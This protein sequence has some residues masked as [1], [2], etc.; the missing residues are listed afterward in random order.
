MDS[1]NRQTAPSPE[2]LWLLEN[3]RPTLDA[4]NQMITIV[5]AAGHFVY[6]N[7][8]AARLDGTDP[9]QVIGCHILDVSPWLNDSD[10]T[11]LR[12]LHEQISFT[13]S[14]QAYQG[15][16]GQH[17]HYVHSATPL[18]GQDGTLI[19]AM[20]VGRTVREMPSKLG[21]QTPPPDILTADAALRSQVNHIDIFGATDLPILIYGESGTGKELFARRAHAQSPRASRPMLSL[22]CAAIPDTLLESTLFG[23]TKGAFTGAENRKGLFTL[24]DGA[25]LFL[26]EINS[27]PISLQGKL[28]RVLQDGSFLPLG[29]SQPQTVDVRLIA[30]INQHP[31]TAIADGR[32]RNDLYY[33]LSVGEIGTIP[34]RDR[35]DDILL[36]SQ[37]FIS[38]FAPT[39]RPEVVELGEQ[40]KKTLTSY[41][42][43]GNVRELE[44]LIRR[45]LLL[46]K[47]GS[48]LEHIAFSG[49]P[50]ASMPEHFCSTGNLNNHLQQT[51]ADSIL[52][53]LAACHS[54]VSKTAKQLGI[55]R[56]TLVSKMKRLGMKNKT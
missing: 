21:E 9:E 44:N 42:W 20:E 2:L 40:A 41:H 15:F 7:Q 47:N 19:G 33:R 14:Y 56:T 49:A 46:H 6:Y 43:P 4:L 13:D 25:T 36:L 32:L 50:S 8:S 5:D 27:M 10:S 22:N 16:G 3:I 34:L 35:P 17:L 26:D 31:Q 48:S 52:Q 37:V 39:L 12:C 23:T 38:Q 29:G 1:G 51:E 54:N 24:A 28:L 30:A 11:L 45:S 53:A 18:F 55:P